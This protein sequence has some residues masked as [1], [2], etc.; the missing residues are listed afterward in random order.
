MQKHGRLFIFEGPDDSGK[1]TLSLAFAEHLRSKGIKCD[2][3][4]FPG[5]D[6]GTLGKLVNNVHH[7]PQTMGVRSII[8]SSLQLLHVA[9]HVDAIECKILPAL[10][11]GRSVVLDRF[12]W[13]TWVYGKVSGVNH[14]ILKSIIR[15]ERIAWGKA[16]PTI[17]FLITRESVDRTEN[18][19]QLSTEY[20]I[21]ATRE[22]R[23]N[24]VRYIENEGTVAEAL[25]EIVAALNV[26]ERASNSNGPITSYNQH[27]QSQLR[28]DEKP[29][30]AVAP[31]GF[32][33]LSPAKPT[34]VFDTYWRFASKR[35]DIFFRRFAG[36]PPP[37]TEDPVLLEYK[38][39]NAYRASDRVSQYLIKHVIYEG[40][41]SIEEIFF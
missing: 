22:A 28:L 3:F 29:A 18:Y 35:Q 13:S 20:A 41:Q 11:S 38:F 6:V 33:R 40:D 36:D 8:P 24:R 9:A 10:K 32:T 34:I 5:R 17:I 4:A 26:N 30:F 7:N 25:A 16:C 27:K 14:N 21:L 19:K 39:T 15:S 2:H 12:W 23:R 1:T 31:L 37:W